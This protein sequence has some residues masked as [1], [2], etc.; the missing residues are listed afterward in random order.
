MIGDPGCFGNRRRCSSN[1][2]AVIIRT[3]GKEK[4][5][6]NQVRKVRELYRLLESRESDIRDNGGWMTIRSH[7]HTVGKEKKNT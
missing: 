2:G 7:T 5:T 6:E 1:V 4:G 3:T